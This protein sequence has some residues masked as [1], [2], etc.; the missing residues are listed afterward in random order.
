MQDPNPLPWGAQDR[1]KEHIIVQHFPDGAL[2]PGQ[3]SESWS[4]RRV[5][6]T[7][8]KTTGDFGLH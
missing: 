1:F 5:A 2:S 8:L 4:L 6:S 3:E 7:Q